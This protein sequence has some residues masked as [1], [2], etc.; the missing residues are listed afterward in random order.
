MMLIRRHKEASVLDNLPPFMTVE[1]A[2][3]VLQLGRSKAYELTVEFEASAGRSGL[4]FVR[5]GRQKR[6]PR[7]AIAR[8]MEID[9]PRPP[10]A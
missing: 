5:L 2:A 7:N 1:Q 3:E 6:V 9:V 10:L 8:L 4:P